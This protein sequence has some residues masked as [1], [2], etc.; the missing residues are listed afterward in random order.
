[1]ERNRKEREAGEGKGQ[2]G[3]RGSG[4]KEKRRGDG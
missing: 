2:N 4:R 3:K 1:M